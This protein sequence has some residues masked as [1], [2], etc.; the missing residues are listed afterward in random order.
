M[1]TVLHVAEN[2]MGEEDGCRRDGSTGMDHFCVRARAWDRRGGEGVIEQGD[3]QETEGQ[4][5]LM[6]GVEYSRGH[7]VSQVVGA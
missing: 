5:T 2:D 4:L 3:L 7:T 6:A 1:Q